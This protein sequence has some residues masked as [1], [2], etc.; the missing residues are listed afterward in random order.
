M[1]SLLLLIFLLGHTVLA[2]DRYSDSLALVAIKEANPDANILWSFKTS[3]DTWSGVSVQND[4]VVSLNLANGGDFTYKRGYPSAPLTVLPTEIGNLTALEKLYIRD[5]KLYSL[6]R[7]ICELQNLTH[8][9]VEDNYLDS[10]PRALGNLQQLQY[11]NISN[12][13]ISAFPKSLKNVNGLKK[14]EYGTSNRNNFVKLPP[15]KMGN[16][17][18]Y[19]TAYRKDKPSSDWEIY[20]RSLTGIGFGVFPKGGTFNVQAGIGL[21]VRRSSSIAYS[22][23]FKMTPFMAYDGRYRVLGR[24]YHCGLLGMGIGFD[25]IRSRSSV[26]FTERHHKKRV[27]VG[28]AISLQLIGGALLGRAHQK[29][30]VGGKGGIKIGMFCDIVGVEVALS[31]FADEWRGEMLFSFDLLMAGNVGQALGALH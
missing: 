4:R 6:P 16:L 9:Y 27:R 20:L 3:I 10:L 22:T 15:R 28:E 19:R 12:N 7:E 5:N 11:L 31:N 29:F 17:Y 23:S 26:V 1:K 13:Q 24:T 18:R 8:L 14:I 30:A 2:T 21:D 25:D